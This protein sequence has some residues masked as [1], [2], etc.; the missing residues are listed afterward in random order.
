M[1]NMI[2]TKAFCKCQVG[3]KTQNYLE[4]S[5]TNTGIQMTTWV[6]EISISANTPKKTKYFMFSIVDFHVPPMS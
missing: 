2:N 6:S 1:V 3:Y 5:G 4:E